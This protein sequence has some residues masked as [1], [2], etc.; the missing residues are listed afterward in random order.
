M[1]NYRWFSIHATGF[2]IDL[3]ISNIYIYV[4]ADLMRMG[5][6]SSFF[7]GNALFTSKYTDFYRARQGLCDIGVRCDTRRTLGLSE[8]RKNSNPSRPKTLVL[9]TRNEIRI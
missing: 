3:S 2:T 6:S 8:K 7:K 9:K 5:S 4:Y 1:I